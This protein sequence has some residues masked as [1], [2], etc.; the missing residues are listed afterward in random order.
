LKDE[1]FQLF[2]PTAVAFRQIGDLSDQDFQFLFRKWT[3]TDNNN[4][5][6][7]RVGAAAILAAGFAV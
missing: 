5:K 1:L 7:V 6:R 3:L 4:R 2:V